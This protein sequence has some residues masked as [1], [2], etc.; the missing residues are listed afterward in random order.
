MLGFDYVASLTRVEW[1]D[2]S[3]VCGGILGHAFDP[4]ALAREAADRAHKD[5]LRAQANVILLE[6]Y[7]D[8][9]V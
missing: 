4:E 6:D 9:A 1:K 5:Y 3:T 7:K 8:G 2:G